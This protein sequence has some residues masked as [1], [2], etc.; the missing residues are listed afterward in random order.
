MSVEYD[1]LVRLVMHVASR[2]LKVFKE[3]LSPLIRK[4]DPLGLYT[5]FAFASSVLEGANE[6][7]GRLSVQSL[8]I[9]YNSTVE[10]M[11]LLTNLARRVPSL[12]R[13]ELDK[14][15]HPMAWE[16]VCLDIECVTFEKM[17]EISVLLR[18]SLAHAISDD[19][20][21]KRCSEIKQETRAGKDK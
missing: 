8:Q 12:Y 10:S 11:V 19:A 14:N 7:I 18:A 17:K 13:V 1:P 6:R 21:E 2:D 15:W 16:S 4:D 20:H 5:S 3:N 9:T